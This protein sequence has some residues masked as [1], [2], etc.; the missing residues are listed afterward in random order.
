[1]TCVICTEKDTL[2]MIRTDEC[3]HQFHKS[4][5]KMWNKSCPIC[6]TSINK[7]ITKINKRV[8][9]TNITL[10]YIYKNY[11][12]FE[13]SKYENDIQLFKS[14]TK[15]VFIRR[16]YWATCFTFDYTWIQPKNMREPNIA[17]VKELHDT[18]II[19]IP[20]NHSLA[21]FYL[22][23]MIKMGRVLV[24]DERNDFTKHKS[25]EY[26]QYTEPWSNYIKQYENMMN[27]LRE[28]RDCLIDEQ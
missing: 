4:C 20:I 15:T 2:G 3:N 10:N 25:A 17:E 6:R 8:N 16:Q 12:M 27:Y 23:D 19:A 1:M 24:H 28:I 13:G 11:N 5:L 26:Y 14:D 7:T 22:D 21:D 9:I 18:K